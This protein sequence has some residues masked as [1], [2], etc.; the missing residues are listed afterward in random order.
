MAKEESFFTKYLLGETPTSLA[1]ETSP[2]AEES[3]I[4]PNKEHSPTVTV[5]VSSV[6]NSAKE[7]AKLVDAILPVLKPMKIDAGKRNNAHYN[8]DSIPF[9]FTNHLEKMLLELGDT[10][11]LLS[12]EPPNKKNDISH[13]LAETLIELPMFEKS[14]GHLLGILST[15]RIDPRQGGLATN[16]ESIQSYKD[17]SAAARMQDIFMKEEKNLNLLRNAHEKLGS[18]RE[19]LSAEL[20]HIE[21]YGAAYANGKVTHGKFRMQENAQGV[22]IS[23]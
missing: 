14:I 10:L 12:V 6:K 17:K 20:P 22:E 11:H 19:K 15:P 3:R 16:W 8:P 9:S 7:M 21:K 18:L 5:Q 23:R 2:Y 1:L 4:L 13:Q